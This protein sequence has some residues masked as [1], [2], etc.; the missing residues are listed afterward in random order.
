MKPLFNRTLTLLSTTLLILISLSC[1][2]L[3]GRQVS[4]EH[5]VARQIKDLGK[6]LKTGSDEQKRRA[7]IQLAEIESEKASELLLRT[8]KNNLTHKQGNAGPPYS[9]TENALLLDALAKR[10]YKKALPTLHKMLTIKEKRLGT[11]REAVAAYIYRI[12]PQPV[13]YTVEGELKTYPPPKDTA[14]LTN[15]LGSPVGGEEAWKENSL[16]KRLLNILYPMTS[17]ETGGAWLIGIG[18]A[19]KSSL[20]EEIGLPTL[21]G[22]VKSGDPLVR[23]YAVAALGF[24][25][26]EYSSEV[27]PVLIEAARDKDPRVRFRGVKALGGALRANA[28]SDEVS[29]IIPALKKALG[30]AEPEV[31][32]AAIEPLGIYS[33]GRYDFVKEQMTDIVPLLVSALGDKKSYVRS[34]AALALALIGPLTDQVVP[35]LIRLLKSPEL[36]DRGSAAQ[37]LG[38]I[39]YTISFARRTDREL[40]KKEI[41]GALLALVNDP[42]SGV[43]DSVA[44]SLGMVGPDVRGV[45]PSLIRLTKDPSRYVRIQAAGGLGSFKVEKNRIVPALVRMLKVEDEEAEVIEHVL[46]YLK[47]MGREAHA[48]AP[49]VRKFLKHENPGIRAEAGAT[50]EKIEPCPAQETSNER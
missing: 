50:L 29:V 2:T 25:F 32:L 34:G 15:S 45:I 10:K 16:N 20:K 4:Y 39:T 42:G 24:L 35:S 31:R 6:V 43:R 23:P 41:G 47:K 22:L 5:D 49:E 3:G 26:E 19:S 40:M 38:T 7:I 21:L 36:S 48:A 18:P 11:F 37:A 17:F 12:S 30:D 46:D 28:K 44:A 27:L 13:N 9:L 14:P 33:M 1:P 8:L